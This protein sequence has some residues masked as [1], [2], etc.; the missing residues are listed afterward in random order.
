[1]LLKYKNTNPKIINKMKNLCKFR[2]D[3]QVST[4]LK[5]FNAI[6]FPMVL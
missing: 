4:E 3:L 5:V 2:I 6:N 1:M